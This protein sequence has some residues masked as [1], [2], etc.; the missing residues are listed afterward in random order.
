MTESISAFKRFIRLLKLEREEI[1][2]IYFFAIISGL[3]QLTLPLGVQSIVGILMGATLVTSVYVLI[4]IVVFGVLI[5]GVTQINQMR[6]IE[7]VQ[8]RLFTRYAFAFTQ[9]LPQVDLSEHSDIYF[10]EKTNRFFD[11]LTIQKGLAKILL[12][13]PLASIQ[14]VF[15][16]TL[17]A[18]YHP[19]F[20]G[21]G[22]LLLILLGFMLKYTGKIGLE[23]SIKESSYKYKV[24]GWLQ[25]IARYIN[26]FKFNGKTEYHLERTN[27]DLVNY[28]DARTNHFKVLLS[29]YRLLVGFKIIIT[30]TMLSV[31]TYLVLN[32][33]LNIGEFI[34]AEIVILSV[35]AAS[36]KLINR[37][38]SFYDLLTGLEKLEFITDLKDEQEGGV[39]YQPTEQGIEIEFENL[40]FAY[41][42]K[43]PI[44]NKLS[45]HVKPGELVGIHGANGSGKSTLLKVFAGILP[46]TSGKL[47]VN[48]IPLANYSLLSYRSHCSLFA[49]ESGIFSGTVL[50]NIT[51]GDHT[52]TAQQIITLCD[53]L[54][55]TDFAASF[56]KGFAT[57]LSVGGQQLDF[58]TSARILLLRAL[59]KPAQLLLLDDLS[60]YFNAN[61]QQRILQYLKRERK[62]TTIILISEENSVLGECKHQLHFTTQA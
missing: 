7:K 55:L 26:T 60:V 35:I 14:I 53:Q 38:E 10:P 56:D 19:I 43:S 41:P 47:M 25:E 42:D 12:D 33:Q 48:R 36:E 31:G 52:I 39:A 57:K 9:K 28:L 62:N 45:G 32:Q 50:D 5:V 49:P 4:A 34:A 59:I 18:L 15:G 54:G 24:A 1:T 16:L 20:I 58:S 2:S 37:L 22:A 8:Q 30:L 29:Q 17:L 40:T 51:L 61:T 3:V 13:L 27:Q 21:F 46:P 11:T 23:T 44:L 6:I